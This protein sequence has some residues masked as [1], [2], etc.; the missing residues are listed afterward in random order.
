MKKKSSLDEKL[1]DT[2]EN[3]KL[4]ADNPTISG[5][6]TTEISNTNPNANA[7]ANFNGRTSRRT[8]RKINIEASKNSDG[9]RYKNSVHYPSCDSRDKLKKYQKVND[10]QK[11]PISATDSTNNKTVV[12]YNRP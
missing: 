6:F 3:Q 2:E 1:R 9:E 11:I 12:H 10:F 7:N 5:S 4:L 8:R